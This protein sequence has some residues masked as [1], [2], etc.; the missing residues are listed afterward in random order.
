MNDDVRRTIYA[1]IIG[2]LAIVV[3]WLGFIYVSSCGFTLNCYQARPLVIRTPIPTLIPVEH[4]D[5][6]NGTT[7]EINEFNRCMIGATDLIAAWVQAGHAE[8]EPFPFTDL[9]GQECEGTF[10]ED[11]QHLFVD[12]NLWEP[13]ALG[14]VSCHNAELTERSSGLDLSSYEAISLGTRRVAEASSPGTDI[15]GRDE[16]ENSI[17]YDVLVNQGL[18]PQGHSP[19]E[20]PGQPILYAGQAVSE[21]DVTATTTPQ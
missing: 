10:T 12:N 6:G 2:F 20:P 5:A 4:R 9:N 15:F 11:I 3:T 19:D 17:L 7:V 16:W 21:E 18:T 1:T 13:G 8:S 14:C